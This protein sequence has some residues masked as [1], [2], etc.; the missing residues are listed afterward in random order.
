MMQDDE[1]VG[2]VEGEC[3]WCQGDHM[4]EELL[5]FIRAIIQTM[6]S[7]KQNDAMT[8]IS[9]MASSGRIRG[10]AEVTPIYLDGDD[11][12]PTKAKDSREDAERELSKLD[13]RVNGMSEV[14]LGF[15]SDDEHESGEF[16]IVMG[17]DEQSAHK[18]K[19]VLLDKDQKDTLTHDTDNTDDQEMFLDLGDDPVIETVVEPVLDLN[20]EDEHNY[21]T[22]ADELEIAL[23]ILD[24]AT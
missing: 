1:F 3:D 17:E 7:D 19:R 21:R 18:I 8:A 2:A 15:D 24:D 4:I 16:E 12:L 9:R 10:A 6:P 13:F 5:K 22:T 14:Y 11:Q 20:V 23:R